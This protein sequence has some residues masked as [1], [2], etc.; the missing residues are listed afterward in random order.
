[1]DSEPRKKKIKTENDIDKTD[2]N[3]ISINKPDSK[4]DLLA[5]QELSQNMHSTRLTR[6]KLRGILDKK[7]K[8]NGDIKVEV[9]IKSEINGHTSDTGKRGR[10]AKRVLNND[11]PYLN[12]SKQNSQ[13]RRK[14]KSSR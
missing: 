6:R 7:A 14:S 8:R 10:T 5:I 4:E 1:M 3:L 12:S 11:A 2:S 13:K 9:D